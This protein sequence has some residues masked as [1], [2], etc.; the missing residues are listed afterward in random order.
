[1]HEISIIPSLSRIQ[2]SD[3]VVFDLR[4]LTNIEKL[5]FSDLEKKLDLLKGLMCKSIYTFIKRSK[6]KAILLPNRW[7]H[8][9]RTTFPNEIS[10]TL[11]NDG[12]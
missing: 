5:L 9:V 6:T 10:N 12:K 4:M 3:I 7:T 2:T 1:M 11:H 8:Y